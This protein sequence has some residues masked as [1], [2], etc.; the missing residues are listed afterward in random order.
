MAMKILIGY[1]GSVDADGALHDLALAGL[2]AKVEAHV[3]TATAPWVMFGTEGQIPPGFALPYGMHSKEM[4]KEARAEAERA[5]ASLRRQFPAW[6][7]RS[8]AVLGD[9]AQGLLDAAD[10]WK[11]ALIVMGSHGRTALGR[12][13]MGSTSLHVLHYARASVRITRPRIRIKQGPPRILI[14][15]DGS[16]GAEIALEAVTSRSWPKGSRFLALGLFD[17][18]PIAGAYLG[19][20]A[21]GFAAMVAVHR[22]A[23]LEKAVTAAAERLERAGLSAQGMMREGDPRSGL[24]DEA[25][26]WGADCIFLGSRGLGAWDRIL[27]GSV[28]STVASH[29]S[30]TV[31]VV[32]NH[33]RS[34]G[35]QAPKGTRA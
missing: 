11:P 10:R 20:G 9:P 13:L 19:E 3:V 29:A 16:V 12:L 4:L 35:R 8:Q 28:S 31:E 27:L 14:A 2:P 21:A 34:R 5:A 23:V 17:T 30:C 33:R 7:V 24:V 18:S 22:R 15:V 32:R 1:D 26:D 6:S 25:R